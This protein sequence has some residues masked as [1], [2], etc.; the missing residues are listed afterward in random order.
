MKN[1]IKTSV[2]AFLIIFLLLIGTNEILSQ[3]P[4]H[5]NNGGGPGS[6]NIPVGGG[7]PIGGGILILIALAAGYGARKVYDMRKIAQAE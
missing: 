7:A 2:T 6:G 1:I 4:P 5:P 3:V